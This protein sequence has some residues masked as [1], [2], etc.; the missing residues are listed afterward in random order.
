MKKELNNNSNNIRYFVACQCM[1]ED[2]YRIHITFLR[3]E[4]TKDK[5]VEEQYESYPHRAT[6]FR[7][8]IEAQNYA[9]ALNYKA[10]HNYSYDDD[11]YYV[12]AIDISNLPP[13]IEA[14]LEETEENEPVS[15]PSDNGN[16]ETA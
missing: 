16:G 10:H 6:Q 5:K 14:H 3:F 8:E 13:I 4:W 11:S 9:F 2:H 1:R 12:V 7:T 15:E